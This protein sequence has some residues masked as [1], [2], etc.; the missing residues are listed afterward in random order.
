VLGLIGMQFLT[1]CELII[2]YEKNLMY[3][4]VINKR[5]AGTYRHT[6]LNDTAAYYTVP[7]DLTD[8][9]MIVRS[10]M[11]GKKLRFVIDCAAETSILD[12]RL[13]DK[14][15]E[16]LSVTGKVS[17]MGVGNKKVDAVTGNL[18]DFFISNHNIKDMPVLITNL[19]KTCFSQGGC[20]DGVL[21]IDG[22]SVRKIGF[23]F[24]T[25]KMYIWK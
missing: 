25:L 4:H 3:F 2:D 7:F 19:E 12:S 18:A 21:G 23:N 20:V 24:T 13:P 11:E 5:E 10:T 8:N 22:L 14:I 16:S 9:R 1:D 15:F 6:M 17:L